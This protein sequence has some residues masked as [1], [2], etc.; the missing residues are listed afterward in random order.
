MAVAVL[1]TVFLARP[2][3]AADAV[4]AQSRMVTKSGTLEVGAPLKGFGGWTLKDGPWSM[5]RHKKRNAKQVLVVSFFATW[6]QPCVRAFPALGAVR[7]A[8]KPEELEFILVSF[9]QEGPEVERF[10]EEHRAP[11]I[12]VVDPF[13]K[14]GERFGVDRSLPRTFVID[15]GGIVRAIFVTEGKDFERALSV[16]VSDA[17]AAAQAQR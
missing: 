17:M 13:Q 11:G 15:P 9:G 8:F 7:K 10:V 6:C 4:P 12:V 2:A 1:C 16:A 5:D 3:Q 14:I